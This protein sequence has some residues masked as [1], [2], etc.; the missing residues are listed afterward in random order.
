MP[1][2][3]A[4]LALGLALSLLI[5][6]LAAGVT[7]ARTATPLAQKRDGGSCADMVRSTEEMSLRSATGREPLVV[8]GPE[9]HI[10]GPVADK[11]KAA[12]DEA[13]T[14]DGINEMA[15]SARDICAATAE[16]DF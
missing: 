8:V 15:R 1:R 14:V 13:W 5:A 10:S 3:I 9:G 7:V 4:G 16:G 2:L 12:A 6:L 11:A